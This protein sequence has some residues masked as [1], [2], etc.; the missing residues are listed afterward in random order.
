MTTKPIKSEIQ[1]ALNKIVDKYEEV[2][3]LIGL[4]NLSQKTIPKALNTTSGVV[5][6]I[7]NN[8]IIREEI[9]PKNL[10]SVCAVY[11]I[12]QNKEIEIQGDA[13]FTDKANNNFPVFD[14]CI[15]FNSEDGASLENIYFENCANKL[16]GRDKKEW[17][18]SLGNNGFW[19]ISKD[20]QTRCDSNYYICVYATHD[21]L[22]G[23]LH[24][25]IKDIETCEI[26]KRF[27]IE[28]SKNLS[29]F[30]SISD[31]TNSELVKTSKKICAINANRCAY[32]IAK[33]FDVEIEQQEYNNG[34][35]NIHTG[36]SYRVGIPD[37]LTYYG[38]IFN[39]QI[40]YEDKS[41]ISCTMLF[42]KSASLNSVEGG[43][44]IP[45]G[46]MKG[47]KLYGGD[48]VSNMIQLRN[49]IGSA[50]PCGVGYTKIDDPNTINQHD[51]KYICR[52]LF[53][54]GKQTNKTFEEQNVLPNVVSRK[55]NDTTILDQFIK[56]ETIKGVTLVHVVGYCSK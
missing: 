22:S 21:K 15:G 47:I 53:W 50:I 7:S 18:A 45:E 1:E 41:S 25:I 43:C 10:F 14:K 20:D 38:D 28:S 36:K 39:T 49:S 44:V 32:E 12:K 31:F 4:P 16:K 17:I 42:N 9:F 24:N 48:K 27:S 52:H 6:I 29:D 11:K 34:K 30:N 5:S 23:E 40:S 26:E 46:P 56:S 2:I 35:I 8:S 19:S 51:K 33:I 37:A 3:A 13:F 54:P 55:H